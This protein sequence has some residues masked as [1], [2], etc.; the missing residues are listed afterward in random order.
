MQDKQL[1]D[2]QSQF[3]IGAAIIIRKFHFIDIGR[4]NLHHGPHLTELEFLFRQGFSKGNNIEKFYFIFHNHA[5]TQ[6]NNS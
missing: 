4:K 1:L 3:R 5:P 2:S 6:R